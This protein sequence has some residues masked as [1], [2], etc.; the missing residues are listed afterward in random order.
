MVNNRWISFLSKLKSPIMRGGEY[1]LEHITRFHDELGRPGDKLDVIHVAGTN[2]KGTVT[3]KMASM[4]Q[5]SGYK[6]GMFVSP[7]L[8]SW[9]ERVQVDNALISKK[10]CEEFID[11]YDNLVRKLGLELSFFE[12]FTLLAFYHFERE[13]VDVAVIEV[14]LGGRLDA[15]NI[16]DKSLLSII[17]SIALDHTNILGTTESQICAEKCGII[18]KNSPVLI[19]P[20]V[21]LDVAQKIA[22]ERQATLYISESGK[23]FKEENAFL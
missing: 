5:L 6:T 15:T 3:C 11:V 20:Q 16:L 7:H 14:G 12:F 22:K 21:P 1:S 9:R 10:H 23:N 13:K 19:G 4:L 2:A 18:K 8:F 17:T